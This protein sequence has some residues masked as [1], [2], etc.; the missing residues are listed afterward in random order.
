MINCRCVQKEQLI[1]ITLWQI[2]WFDKLSHVHHQFVEKLIKEVLSINAIFLSFCFL[3]I[4][5]KL[6]CPLAVIKQN[7]VK[8]SAN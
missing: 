4:H 6:V 8:T 3:S 2:E 7:E 5:H 1:R